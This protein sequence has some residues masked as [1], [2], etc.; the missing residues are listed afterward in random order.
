MNYTP[1]EPSF[2]HIYSTIGAAGAEGWL[3]HVDISLATRQD[4][5]YS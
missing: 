4:E 3:A 1:T 5:A 2:A